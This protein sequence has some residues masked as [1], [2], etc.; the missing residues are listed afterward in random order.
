MDKHFFLLAGRLYPCDSGGVEL[1]HH[2]FLQRISKFR[3]T[4]VITNCNKFRKFE[5]EKL[6]VI[7]YPK[8]LFGKLSISSFF[9]HTIQIF[10]NRKNIGL[11]Y[12]PYDSKSWYAPYHL[13]LF[14]KFFSIPYVLRI[15]GGK[16]HPA[17]PFFLHQKLFDY[18][19]GVIT[20]STPMQKEYK[21]RHDKP[22][23]MIPSMLPFK[24]SS[25]SRSSAKRRIGIFENEK[26]ILFVGTIK[27]IKGPDLLL[28]A[29]R[30][31][32]SQYIEKHRLNLVFAG[33]GPL[34]AKLEKSIESFKYK[35][36]IHFLGHVPHV[37]MCDIY[38]AADLFVIPSL[39]EA[40]PLSLS[41]A[42]FNGL[43]TI[44]SDIDT[45]KNIIVPRTNG[46]LFYKGDCDDLA[47]KIKEL[48]ENPKFRSSLGSTAKEKYAL[49]YTYEDMLHGYIQYFES[50]MA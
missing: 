30:R 37:E 27:D 5:S 16:M 36:S 24:E 17:F 33:D 21:G 29:F 1:F 18:A 2:Y 15:S 8:K 12:T 45:I 28:E 4:Y 49:S 40:R 46:L 39:M 42:L 23:R 11:I 26:V 13:I 19:S 25:E 38:R 48:F 47:Q 3:K 14:K 50:I 7:V 31:L 9:N 22:I 6:K 20:V 44:G 34:R 43:P 10:K 32:G 35:T 41:E